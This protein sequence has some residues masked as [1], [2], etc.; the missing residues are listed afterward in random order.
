MIRHKG[1]NI[2]CPVDNIDGG[3]RLGASYVHSLLEEE[4]SNDDIAAVGQATI[5]LSYPWSYTSDE[6]D[7]SADDKRQL[8]LSLSC[9][10]KIAQTRC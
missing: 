5:M 3:R 4:T 9:C 2:Y 10:E 8:R 1:S 6:V 7:Y